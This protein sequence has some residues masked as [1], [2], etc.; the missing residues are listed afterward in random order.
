[1]MLR[2]LQR[3]G[4]ESSA[5]TPAAR[6]R[7]DMGAD[8]PPARRRSIRISIGRE[9]QGLQP[10]DL[11]VN[12]DR[13]EAIQPRCMLKIMGANEVG[14]CPARALAGCDQLLQE[15][16]NRPDVGQ[17]GFPDVQFWNYRV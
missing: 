13:N 6:G 16:A 3:D 10:Q 5:D 1:M 9:L 7:S 17:R 11:A 12:V 2:A 4:E 8:D 14:R 15:I